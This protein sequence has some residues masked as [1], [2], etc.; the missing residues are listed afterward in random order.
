[1]NWK[2]FWTND[3]NPKLKNYLYNTRHI[4]CLLIV[5]VFCIGFSILLKRKDEKWKKIFFTVI[6][7]I[8]LFFEISSRVVNL[9]ITK[10]YS[11]EK[12]SNILLPMYI[13]SIV[14]WFLIIG[15]YTDNNIILEFATICGLIATTAFLLYPA[16]GL[17]R[18]YMTFT[19]LYS[20]ITHMLGFVTCIVM[21]T[22]HKV[23]F[24]TQDLPIILSIFIGMFLY[25]FLIDFYILPGNDHMYLLNDPLELKLPFNY[26]L[27][28][29]VVL[30]V[31]ICSFYIIP[32]IQNKI[33]ERKTDGIKR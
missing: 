23:V 15:L 8:F 10:E 29:G 3:G 5:V 6:A 14:V 2:M 7:S 13:C 26:R 24:R 22:A 32:L 31:Y 28:Y 20:T 33:K 17:N 9:I 4:F 1:M 16:V 11:I 12:I 21:M 27:L 19:Q 25:G 30:F 18:Q